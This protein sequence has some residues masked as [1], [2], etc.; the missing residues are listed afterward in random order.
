MESGTVPVDRGLIDLALS[1]IH[2]ERRTRL[3]FHVA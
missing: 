2:V 3:G 1:E